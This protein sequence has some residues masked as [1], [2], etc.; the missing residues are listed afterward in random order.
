MSRRNS[1][2]GGKGG[3]EFLVECE[4]CKQWIS[5]DSLGL[6]RVKVKK[7]SFVCRACVEGERWEKE[8]GEWKKKAMELAKR[9]G[10]EKEQEIGVWRRD[11]ER[12]MGEWEKRVQRLEERVET[13]EKRGE[14][15]EKE[16]RDE[17]PGKSGRQEGVMEKEIVGTGTDSGNNWDNKEGVAEERRQGGMSKGDRKDER[18]REKDDRKEDE[19][20]V[21]EKDDRKEGEERVREKGS[22]KEDEERVRE[23]DDRKE[24]E[25]RVREKD[26]RKEDEV[27]VREKDYRKEDEVRGEGG[28][29]GEQKQGGELREKQGEK[30]GVEERDEGKKKKKGI[31]TV[32]VIGGSMIRGIEK[33]LGELLGRDFEVKVVSMSGA[34]IWDVRRHMGKWA[35]EKVDCVVVHV[36]TSHI[37]RGT[38]K[39]DVGEFGREAE[40]L[41]EQVDRIFG[42]G[43]GMWSGLVPRVDQ[44]EAGLVSVR[45]G[46]EELVRVMKR[47]GWGYVSHWREFMEGGRVREE[48]FRDG[49]HC[50][51][52]E[53]RDALTKGIGRGVLQWVEGEKKQQSE[54]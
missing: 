17:S 12:R 8:A 54:N 13:G 35:K 18:V 19:E 43:V 27:R 50:K 2:D 52:G 44:G 25:E 28:E 23:K 10:G 4:K 39:L 30:R 36:G 53:G 31:K 42:K 41:V 47:K 49:L 34:K 48:W 45:Q 22:R 26:D 20:R 32:L 46:N 40:R 21:R 14:G 7:I 51:E 3:E 37:N 24:G 38:G 1:R 11:M 6:D 5:G 15:Q 29:V 33:D 9:E 16:G